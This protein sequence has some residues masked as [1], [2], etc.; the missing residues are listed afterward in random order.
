MRGTGKNGRDSLRYGGALDSGG[1]ADIVAV[2]GEQM[3]PVEFRAEDGFRILAKI[4][5]FSVGFGDAGEL[6]EK[7]L[8]RETR[9]LPGSLFWSLTGRKYRRKVWIEGLPRW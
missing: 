4:G 8:P 7:I 6:E 1:A 9:L 3:D 2:F 5:F